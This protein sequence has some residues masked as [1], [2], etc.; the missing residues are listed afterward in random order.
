MTD[1]P[2]T[3]SGQRARL[4]RILRLALVLVV[5][6]VVILAVAFYA[7]LTSGVGPSAA[8]A[9]PASGPLEPGTTR[10]RRVTSGGEERCYLLHAPENLPSDAPVPLV[11]TLH[12]FSM[13]GEQMQA[14]SQ[15]DR[16]AD[17]E[18]FLTAYP[19]GA[20]LPP[21]WNSGPISLIEV[22]DVQF[23]RDLVDDVAA[24]WNVDRARVYLT[25]FSNGGG[26]TILAACEAADLMA[27][28]GLV[29]V[30]GIHAATEDA[31]APAR[32]LPLIELA[33]PVPAGAVSGGTLTT[34]QLPAAAPADLTFTA[35]PGPFLLRLVSVSPDSYLAYYPAARAARWAEL[36]GCA[37]PVVEQAGRLTHTRYADCASGAAVE[38]FR[39]DG[40]GHQWP[41]G[42]LAPPEEPRAAIN[43]TEAMWQ[44]FT[45]QTQ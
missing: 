31:C 17:R 27:A 36:N 14:T 6:V 2:P 13:N 20:G 18:G 29:E 26:M 43:A 15:W 7:M 33:G 3:H 30:G 19:D 21:R 45:A 4:W 37:E 32:P 1:Q 35:S 40:M 9:D 42:E 5:G 11:I 25:G 8:C 24:L 22:D 34:A 10:A 41:V 12:G 44:F 23:M 16:V 39:I 38:Y 28:L